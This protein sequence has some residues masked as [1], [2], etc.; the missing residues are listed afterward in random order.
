MRNSDMAPS[1]G[2]P[3]RPNAMRRRELLCRVSSAAACAI[4][5]GVL[6]GQKPASS[7][8]A[9][10]WREVKPGY[11]YAFPR[12]HMS[13]P[14]FQTE[15]WYF[16]GNLS[17]GGRPFGYELTFFRQGRRAA[18]TQAP[19]EKG[20]SVWRTD[21]LYL[22]HLALSDIGPQQ[23]HHA[24]RLNRAGPGLA[25][26]DA[27]RGLIWNGNWQVQLEG[28]NSWRLRAMDPRFHLDLRLRS[29]K[30]PVIHGRDGMHRKAPGEGRASHYVSLTRLETQGTLE[31]QGASFAV[32]G[33][34]WMDHEFFSSLLEGGVAGWD[35]FSLQLEDGSELMIYQLRLGEAGAA[36]APGSVSGGDF[37]DNSVGGTYVDGAGGTLDLAQTD[38]QLRPTGYHRTASGANYPVEWSIL[39]P[40]LKL[41]M[42]VKPR[43]KNQELVSEQS[44]GPTYWEGAIS[45]EGSRDTRPVA[46]SG[47]LELTGYAGRVGNPTDTTSAIR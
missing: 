7:S 3:A 40:R 8:P 13:H 37:R 27:E 36:G 41:S 19:T 26:V 25:G 38:I 44:V 33:L 18:G 12:D 10:T 17:S 43:M 29:S 14:E 42:Q 47:Y 2:T 16:T 32:Q 34:S 21:Q 23:F 1:M 20:T 31:V 46:G 22:A 35:W 4:S 45:V 24:E 39:V 6:L 5:P 30:G 15:W 28:Q 11:V 9:P